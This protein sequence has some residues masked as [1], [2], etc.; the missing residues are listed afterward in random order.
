MARLPGCSRGAP[1]SPASMH[2]VVTRH[3]GHSFPVFICF[4]CSVIGLRI[5]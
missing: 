5:V 1:D 2:L 4:F 3:C